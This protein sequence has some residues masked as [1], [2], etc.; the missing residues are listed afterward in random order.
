MLRHAPSYI[1]LDQGDAAP[2]PGGHR[3]VGAAAMR[4]QLRDKRAS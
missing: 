3:P 1:F 2:D 4:F